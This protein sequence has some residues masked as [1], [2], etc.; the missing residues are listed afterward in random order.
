M[1]APEPTVM[2][3]IPSSSG[4]GVIRGFQCSYY[5]EPCLIY[6]KPN[7][8]FS[9]NIWFSLLW[10]ASLLIWDKKYV[11]G[12][13]SFLTSFIN[14]YKV[15]NSKE[16]CIYIYIYTTPILINSFWNVI[17]NLMAYVWWLR[18]YYLID[19]KTNIIIATNYQTDKITPIALYHGTDKTNNQADQ[20]L[21]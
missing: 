8:L 18:V 15:V 2:D 1:I 17:D 10:N 7:K 14:S 11:I 6:P 16:I 20:E 13:D 21:G 3:W 4:L 19:W 5:I 9:N 12:N